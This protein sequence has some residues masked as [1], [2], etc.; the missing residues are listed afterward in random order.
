[1]KILEKI[2]THWKEILLVLFVL[3][4]LNK[5][6]QSCNRQI[7]I[8]KQEKTI[9]QMDSTILMLKAD[10]LEKLHTIQ[11]LNEKINTEKEKVNTALTKGEVAKANEQVAKAER[12][13]A[14]A[15]EKVNKMIQESKNKGSN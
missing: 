12:D 8:D 10:T 1:M 4:S 3:F 7:K 2:K 14:I 6:T 5:C 11:L 9:Q 15:K 13:A